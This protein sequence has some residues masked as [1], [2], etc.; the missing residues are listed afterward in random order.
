[1]DDI[2]AFSTALGDVLK[3]TNSTSAFAENKVEFAV[4][5]VHHA[6][7]RREVA[8]DFVQAGWWVADGR[9]R[10]I[11]RS[12]LRNR[13]RIGIDIVGGVVLQMIALS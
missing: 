8:A 3:S 1:L 10:A 9:S 2:F 4:A 13:D 11:G 7:S 12:L 5:G 6:S